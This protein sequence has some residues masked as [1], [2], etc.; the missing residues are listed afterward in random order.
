[1]PILG[2]A[3]G[4]GPLV[5]L[6]PVNDTPYEISPAH[7]RAL[8]DSGSP[9]RILDCREPGEHAICRIEG[10]DLIPMRSISQYL[11]EL[12]EETRPLVVYCHH[13]VRSLNVVEWLRRQGIENCQSMSGGID[14]WSLTVDPSVARY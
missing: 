1:M 12:E 7:V 9:I 14:L 4:W 11:H 8:L 3:D 10:A 13:G 2:R 5:D 6:R